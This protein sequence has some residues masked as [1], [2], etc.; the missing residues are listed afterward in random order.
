MPADLDGFLRHGLGLTTTDDPRN[1]FG[2][3]LQ[4]RD[5]ITEIVPPGRTRALPAPSIRNE[6]IGLPIAA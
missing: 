4:A 6:F 2:I 3:L 1:Q 5:A